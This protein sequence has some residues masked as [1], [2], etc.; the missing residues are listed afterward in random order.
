MKQLIEIVDKL[1]AFHEKQN[2][3]K[4]LETLNRIKA[5]LEKSESSF[6][7]ILI[8]RQ[9][10]SKYN[11]KQ[12]L[13]QFAEWIAEN[14]INFDGVWIP[15]EVDILVNGSDKYFENIKTKHGINTTNLVEIFQNKTKTK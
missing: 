8:I 10:N 12:K 13:I 1:I 4:L 14:Y 3:T 6:L 15:T 7:D 9:E 5:R 11:K 2:D